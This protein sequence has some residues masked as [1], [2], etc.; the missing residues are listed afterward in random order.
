MVLRSS[1]PDF[2]ITSTS[3]RVV[4]T[5]GIEYRNMAISHQRFARPNHSAPFYYILSVRVVKSSRAK[6]DGGIQ[7]DSPTSRTLKITVG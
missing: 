1:R 6:I 4:K 7:V 2:S 3:L 5:Q